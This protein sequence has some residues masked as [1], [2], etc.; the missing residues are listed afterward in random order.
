MLVGHL[1]FLERLA[2][3]L[4]IGDADASLVTLEAVAL[5]ALAKNENGWCVDSLMQPKLLP[6]P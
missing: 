5:L 3:L 1:P 4:V 6:A 2:S